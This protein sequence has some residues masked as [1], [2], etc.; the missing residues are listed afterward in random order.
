MPRQTNTASVSSATSRVRDFQPRSRHGVLTKRSKHS[1]PPPYLYLRISVTSMDKR[2]SSVAHEMHMY[3]AQV[4]AAILQ[5]TVRQCFL[6]N[7]C[8][9]ISSSQLGQTASHFQSS[10]PILS[11]LSIIDE[12]KTTQ[13]RNIHLRFF[14]LHLSRYVLPWWYL[15][16]AE[17]LPSAKIKSRIKAVTCMT[18][19]SLGTVH[20]I[21]SNH[22]FA[23]ASVHYKV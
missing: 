2:P 6:A 18:L 5:A 10:T 20:R 13:A 21:L 16:R 1:S 7:K 22:T 12:A 8:S 11:Q 9:L 4:T 14:I 23:V 15:V 17:M 19:F 3:S